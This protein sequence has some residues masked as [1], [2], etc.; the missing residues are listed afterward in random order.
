[1]T[2][3]LVTPQEAMSNLFYD[4]NRYLMEHSRTSRR[5]PN[6]RRVVTQGGL[7]IVRCLD[8]LTLLAD[9]EDYFNGE[10]RESTLE[11]EYDSDMRKLPTV[12]EQWSTPYAEGVYTPKH[13]Q[14]PEIAEKLGS[15]ILPQYEP[16]EVLV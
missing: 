13:R 9:F 1:M 4:T 3:R 2:S 15:L 5:N 8:V 14:F 12:E 6:F 11:V 10:L 16:A 7:E